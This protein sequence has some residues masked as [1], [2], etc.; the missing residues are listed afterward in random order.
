MVLPNQGLSYNTV[1][2]NKKGLTLDLSRPEGA[3]LALKL[4][5][6]SD[7]VLDNMRP[8][9]MVKLGLG[10]EA[11]R[12]ERPDIVVATLSSRGATG[13]ETNYL[14]FATIHQAV[15]GLA[16]LSGHPDDHPTHGSAGD[17]DLMNGM[18]T[19]FAILAALHHRRQTGEGQ[20]IDYSQCEGV[21]ALI[22]E[23]F[24]EYQ[25]TGQ[26][27]ERKGNTHPYHA[28]HAVYR[29]W[30]V[31]RWLAL[32]VHD[33]EQF[34]ALARIIGRPELA[35][36]LRFAG[37]ASR[38]QNEAALDEIVGTWIR[39]RDRDWMVGEFS[40]AGLY[41]APSRDGRDLYADPHLKARG[42][43][44][45]VNHPELGPLE[46][47]GPP[48][49]ISGLDLP[50]RPAPLLGEHNDYVLREILGLGADEVEELR[51]REI[52]LPR[53]QEGRHLER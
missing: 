2:Q 52:I 21:S 11:L 13:P 47:V 39:Q 22:G 23:A 14:G 10:Y 9:A 44:V 6:V 35:Q 45:T 3:R 43:F 34:A 40:R 1:N 48:F 31:D 42:A 5:A 18:S 50:V 37:R 7:V 30:G 33:D 32:E 16:Y 53:G 25:M 51:N 12:R 17:A 49:R 4:A 36:D 41:A 8:G 24:L 29:C 38:K 20:F 28:P 15:G 27:P 19:T 26:A 46:L